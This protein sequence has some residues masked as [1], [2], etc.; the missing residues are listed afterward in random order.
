MGAESGSTTFLEPINVDYQFFVLE[1]QPYFFYFNLAQFETIFHFLGISWLFL[2]L[3]LGSKTFVGP[4]YVNNQLWFW[5][6]SL[7]FFVFNFATFGASFALFGSLRAIFWPFW[8]F[9][10]VGVRFKNFFGTNLCIQLA[11]V[12]KIQPYVFVFDMAEFRAFYALFG[13]FGAIFGVG[14]KFKNFFGTY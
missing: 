10:V 6:Y 2:E 12:L 11:L 8:A 3:L 7:I 9:L 1:V 13:P 5:K 14:V 4:T